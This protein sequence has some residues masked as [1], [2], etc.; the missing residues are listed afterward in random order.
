MRKNTC[1]NRPSFR[2]FVKNF[3]ATNMTDDVFPPVSIYLSTGNMMYFD[4]RAKR[5][6]SCGTRFR[7]WC[8]W[9]LLTWLLRSST[10]LQ[11]ISGHTEISKYTLFKNKDYGRGKVEN[12]NNGWSDIIFCPY[13]CHG[14]KTQFFSEIL[15]EKDKTTSCVCKPPEATSLSSKTCLAIFGRDKNIS[16]TNGT[17]R[18]QKQPSYHSHDEVSKRKIITDANSTRHSLSTRLSNKVPKNNSKTLA[19]FQT[20]ID[21]KKTPNNWEIST[22]SGE[23]VSKSVTKVSTKTLNDNPV[24]AKDVPIHTR[25]NVALQIFPSGPKAPEETDWL[26]N[27]GGHLEMEP[28]FLQDDRKTK[29]CHDIKKDIF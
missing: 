21:E 18:Y 14:H 22:M 16:S 8:L 4:K 27:P 25:N 9:S 28:I 5:S 12:C 13:I 26:L 2:T 6:G 3:N 23:N 7:R 29:N 20:E 10:L 1:N 19:T 17:P 11:F 15:T 24:Q